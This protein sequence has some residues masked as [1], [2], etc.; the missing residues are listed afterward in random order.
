MKKEKF[1]KAGNMLLNI[2]GFL[3]FF[4]C[5]FIAVRKENAVPPILL[6]LFVCPCSYWFLRRKW[7]ERR[8][9]LIRVVRGVVL[10][11]AFF[12]FL[13]VIWVT[14][15]FRCFNF[16]VSREAKE[17]F[18][19]HIQTDE[20]EYKEVTGIRK[21]AH[22]DYQEVTATIKYEDRHTHQT[23]QREIVL[24]FDQCQNKFFETF[25]EMRQY[26]RE[27]VAAYLYVPSHLN[28]VEINK[29]IYEVVDYLA[30]GNFDGIWPLVDEG[31]K[32]GLT[33]EKREAWQQKLASLG[34]YK[35]IT[36]IEVPLL[37]DDES[38]TQR[39]TVLVTAGFAEG[40]AEIELIINEEL[41]VLGIEVK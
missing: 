32:A 28:E 38:Y 14:P 37:E 26:R 3:L 2:Y 5:V 39:V 34:A 7:G 10:G 25:E 19:Q 36:N 33:K 31:C 13:F 29:R 11:L 17:Y 35:Q 9:V 4:M 22:M 27:N 8:P 40:E 15:Y 1:L 18:Q 21:M 12:V 41:T 6:A 24:Y 23:M 30:E 16:A 20:I